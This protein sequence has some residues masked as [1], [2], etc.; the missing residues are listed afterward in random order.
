MKE[1]HEKGVA[2]HL[3][4]ESCAGF[5]EEAGEALTEAH[6]GQV[7]SSEIILRACRS[8]PDGEKAT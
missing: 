5:R 2:H 1:P 8:S 3:D 7:L 6:L 4:L